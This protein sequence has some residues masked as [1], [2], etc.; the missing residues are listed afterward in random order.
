M[1]YNEIFIKVMRRLFTNKKVIGEQI[2]KATKITNFI[3]NTSTLNIKTETK[4]AASLLSSEVKEISELF[5][6]AINERVENI[7]IN[8]ELFRVV[9]AKGLSSKENININKIIPIEKTI[10]QEK[11]LMETIEKT[12]EDDL[13]IQKKYEELGEKKAIK[14]NF[15]NP[16]LGLS[17]SL[18]YYKSD[19][20]NQEL[21]KWGYVSLL[22]VFPSLFLFSF[23]YYKR[24]RIQKLIRQINGLKHLKYKVSD[25]VTKDVIQELFKEI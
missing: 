2:L 25:Q 3:T 17:K 6:R 11:S 18:I 9:I 1:D 7:A 24:N 14:L 20:N 16:R 4:F 13:F 22:F 23:G 15:F 19:K 8:G 21:I 12:F 5:S 10:E